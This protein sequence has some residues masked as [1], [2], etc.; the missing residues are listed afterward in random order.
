MDKY[1]EVDKLYM[2]NFTA[3]GTM[4]YVPLRDSSSPPVR[5]KWKLSLQGSRL[6]YEDEVSEILEWSDFHS[7]ESNIPPKQVG[8]PDFQPY[9]TT[10]SR[11]DDLSGMYNLTGLINQES[12]GR[13]KSGESSAHGKSLSLERPDALTY[14][15][16]PQTALWS[17]GRGYSKNI[18]EIVSTSQDSNGM[19]ELKANGIQVGANQEV[20]ELVIDPQ[21]LFIVRSAKRY[22]RG[23]LQFHLRN[24]GSRWI[25]SCLIPEKMELID[26]R[27][28]K[29]VT[30]HVTIDEARFESDTSFISKSFALMDPPY[31]PRLHVIDFRQNINAA[32]SR[33]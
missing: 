30:R 12:I 8:G 33:F 15:L 18:V 29:P 22:L 32:E 11:R 17:A 7:D 16:F 25:G 27:L 26:Y 21:N 10:I 19:I 24:S 6:A 14:M 1:R 9:R 13:W 20:W 28:G 23:N 2:T 31:D 5:K 4:D 3:T